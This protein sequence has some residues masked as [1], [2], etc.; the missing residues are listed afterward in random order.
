MRSVRK[1]IVATVWCTVF[2]WRLIGRWRIA[3]QSRLVQAQDESQSEMVHQTHKS[4]Q[5]SAGISTFKLSDYPRAYN[6]ST[7]KR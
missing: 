7:G 5:Y 4:I 3:I 6:C 1:C 2:I